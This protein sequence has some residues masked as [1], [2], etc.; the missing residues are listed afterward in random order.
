[1]TKSSMPLKVWL[2][3][4]FMTV[5][6]GNTQRRRISCVLW[7]CRVS[8]SEPLR[9]LGAPRNPK[10]KLDL[11]FAPF[12]SHVAK[13]LKGSWI[14]LSLHLHL[15]DQH[16]QEVDIL[17]EIILM[18]YYLCSVSLIKKYIKW[19]QDIRQSKGN[20]FLPQSS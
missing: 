4:E 20:S 14:Q 5:F 1:M 6:G 17:D 19:S 9:I 10:R 13:A 8:E 11:V 12:I 7:G 3:P 18:P 2:R 16:G 15:F